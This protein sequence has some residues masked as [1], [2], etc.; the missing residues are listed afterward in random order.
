MLYFIV[1]SPVHLITQLGACFLCAWCLL[2]FLPFLLCPT[3]IMSISAFPICPVASI[4]S[5]MK[6]VRV[7]QSL[8][9]GRVVCWDA[10][11][12]L[13]ASSLPCFCSASTKLTIYLPWGPLSDPLSQSLTRPLQT[14]PGLPSPLFKYLQL[15]VIFS[16]LFHICLPSPPYPPPPISTY[17]TPPTKQLLH[18]SFIRMKTCPG[19][20]E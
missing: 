7:A 15:S 6:A 14:S 20:L 13:S 19:S 2:I 3:W 17:S 8:P 4:Q 16:A 18:F 5:G 9:L 12:Y 11:C 1:S 10:E